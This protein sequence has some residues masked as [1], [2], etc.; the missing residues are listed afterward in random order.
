MY[1]DT[2]AVTVENYIR[3]HTPPLPTFDPSSS[4]FTAVPLAPQRLKQRGFNQALLLAEALGKLLS[5]SVDANTLV[6]TRETKPQVE[7]ETPKERQENIAGAFAVRENTNLKGKTILL[8]D[9]VYT[10]GATMNECARVLRR[11]G[12]HTVWG[13][14]VARG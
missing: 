2:L 13:V 8:V 10:S 7:C 1:C 9:D 11:A 4:L 14:A 5:I 12:A 3:A 6:R